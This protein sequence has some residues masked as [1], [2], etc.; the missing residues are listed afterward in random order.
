MGAIEKMEQREKNKHVIKVRVNDELFEY[1]SL[2]A[3]RSERVRKAIWRDMVA[4][5][6]MERQ[7]K[8]LKK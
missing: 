2:W 4:Y 5:Q 1:L 3:N 8:G 7:K 6:K